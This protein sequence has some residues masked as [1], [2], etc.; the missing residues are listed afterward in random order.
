MMNC[1]T[2]VVEGL[3]AV[4]MCR[5]GAAR[6]SEAGLQITTLPQLA[7]RLAGGFVWPARSEDLDP[8]IRKA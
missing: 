3:L 6:R 1:R 5:I 7:G 2:I 8:A 4:R